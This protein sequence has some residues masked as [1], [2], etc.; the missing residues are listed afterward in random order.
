MAD[1]SRY[2][3]FAPEVIRDPYPYYEWMRDEA[4]VYE[5][6]GRN[7]W[8][9]SRFDDVMAAL[10]DHDTFSSAG[11][12]GGMAGPMGT[13]AEGMSMRF[14]IFSDPPDHTKLRRLV[15]RPFVPSAIG[16][17][18]PRVREVCEE[19]VD[20]L[21]KENEDGHADLVQHVG[22]PLPVIMIAHMLGIP[23]ERRKDFKRWSDDMMGGT[24]P[25][26]DVMRA[27][28]SSTEMYSFFEGVIEERRRQPG[29]DLVSALVSGP[30]ALNLAE[31]LM[32]CM[33]LLIAG[34]ETT[35]NLVSN[36]ALALFAHPDEARRLR[37]D[38]SLIPIAVEEALRYDSPVQNLGRSATRDVDIHGVTI[39]KGGRVLPLYGSANRDPRHYDE[40]DVFRADRNPTDHMAFGSGIHYCL[41][42]PLA[43]LEARVVAETILRRTK[44]MEISGEPERVINPIVRGLRRLPVSFQ[45]A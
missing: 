3:P 45:P 20:D 6:P 17:L 29:G 19:L 8:A 22:T 34:N 39:P 14:L 23:P 44:K 38:P 28:Q 40:P 37:D 13:A 32:F 36:G 5:V 2:D 10:R 41:G 35:T 21:I 11:A 30:E 31:L 26:F 1:L 16:K 43:R 25:D 18:S 24:S 15:T 12:G 9:L 42:A 33:L 4:P 27:A 7:V